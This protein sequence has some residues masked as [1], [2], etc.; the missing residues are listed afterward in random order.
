MVTQPADKDY[1]QV[2][3]VPTTSTPEQIKEAYRTL[4][5]KY[6]PDVRPTT[7]TEEH[8]PN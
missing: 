1:Y 3:G 4:V 2:L 8:E 5:K 6:H 7:K